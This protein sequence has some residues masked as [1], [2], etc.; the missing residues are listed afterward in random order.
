MQTNQLGP[1]L[2]AL[3]SCRATTRAFPTLLGLRVVPIG[4]WFLLVPALGPF[5]LTTLVTPLVVALVATWWTDRWYRRTFGSVEPE[6]A[7]LGRSRRILYG[8]LAAQVAMAAGSAALLPGPATLVGTLVVILFAT[9][10][11]FGWPASFGSE[12]NLE[13]GALGIVAVVSG[14][15]LVSA[16]HD[17]ERIGTTGDLFSLLAGAILCLAGIIEHRSLSRAFS[18]LPAQ[19]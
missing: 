2:R 15:I 16:S 8:V 9:V 14:A 6:R 11:L 10:V 5:R 18:A 17:P 19:R 1:D 13:S 3:E 4:A 7:R 12:S